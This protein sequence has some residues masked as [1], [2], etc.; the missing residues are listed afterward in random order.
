VVRHQSE[1]NVNKLLA[2]L[3]CGAVRVSAQ[4]PERF[5]NLQV[6]PK[7]ISRDSL[8]GI[9]RGFSFGLGV[10]CVHCHLGEDSPTLAGVDF[11]SDE[12]V[13][14]R[15]A[16]EMLRMVAA[17]NASLATLPSRSDPIEVR[18]A[19]CHRGIPRPISLEDSLFRV[20]A[21]AKGPAIVAAYDSLRAEYFGQSAFDFGP[22][23][24]VRLAERL[25]AGRRHDDAVA[26]LMRNSEAYPRFWGTWWELGRGYEAQSRT[27]DAVAA[28]RAVLERL[29]NHPGAMARLRALGA[30]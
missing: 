20:A 29:P 5:E 26:V 28:Y 4:I 6:F 27:A 11:R 25:N 24:L 2:L 12:R 1:D 22:Q 7:D 14:K 17:V 9:M 30:E 19:T 16:R 13:A 3:L 23:A 18:C 15:K 10:R 8:I 21:G